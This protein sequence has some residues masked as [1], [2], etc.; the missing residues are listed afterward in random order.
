MKILVSIGS[1]THICVTPEILLQLLDCKI[2]K[3]SYSRKEFTESQDTL[4]ISVAKDEWLEPIATE[5]VME[6]VT[7]AYNVQL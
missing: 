4:E 5:S 1:S 3:S 7:G 6:V 2:Y